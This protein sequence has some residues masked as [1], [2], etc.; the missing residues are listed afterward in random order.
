MP[1]NM[2]DAPQA[3]NELAQLVWP[4]AKRVAIVNGLLALVGIGV[5]LYVYCEFPIPATIAHHRL[6][7]FGQP[8]GPESALSY[9]FAFPIFQVWLVVMPLWGGWRA[10]RIDAVEQAQRDEVVGKEGKLVPWAKPM[11]PSAGFL[12]SILVGLVMVEV[13]LLFATIFRAVSAALGST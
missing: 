4:S 10:T 1:E 13:G 2:Q 8:V 6:D 5:A 7:K 11:E 9:L 12:R 3:P